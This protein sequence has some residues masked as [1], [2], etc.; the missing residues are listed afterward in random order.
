MT[1][2]DQQ[3]QMTGSGI[4]RS[5][6]NKDIIKFSVPFANTVTFQTSYFIRSCKTWNILGCDRRHKDIGL[7]TFKSKLKNTRYL[8]YTIVMIRAHG[9]PYMLNVEGRGRWTVT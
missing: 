5:Q 3:W 1:V 7:Y 2:L 6:T 9:N 8:M 4:T